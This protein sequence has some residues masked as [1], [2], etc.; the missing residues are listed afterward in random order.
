MVSIALY[1]LRCPR[2][3]YTYKVD[4]PNLPEWE[5]C[6]T[7]GYSAPF[8]EFHNEEEIDNDAHLTRHE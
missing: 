6:P 2:C 4:C 3:G 5:L 8:D 7:C 1:R